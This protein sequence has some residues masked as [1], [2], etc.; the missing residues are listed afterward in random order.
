MNG[1]METGKCCFIIIIESEAFLHLW[2]VL[3]NVSQLHRWQCLCILESFCRFL[4][5]LIP[6]LYMFELSNL[7]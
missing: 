7:F 4:S 6:S 1:W 2:C 5:L 3:L